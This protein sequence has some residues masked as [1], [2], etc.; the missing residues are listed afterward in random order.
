MDKEVTSDLRVQVRLRQ[1]LRNAIHKLVVVT[2]YGQW[3]NL[4]WS[5]VVGE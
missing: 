5:I 2:E 3:G 4:C 1:P